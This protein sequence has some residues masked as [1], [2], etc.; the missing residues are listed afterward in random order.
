MDGR[1]GEGDHVQAAGSQFPFACP[2]A[3]ASILGSRRADRR[4]AREEPVPET[5][6]EILVGGGHEQ[7]RYRWVGLFLPWT[8]LDACFD[9]IQEPLHSRRLTGVPQQADIQPRLC[10]LVRSPA[11]SSSREKHPLPSCRSV[12]A[13]WAGSSSGFYLDLCHVCKAAH[14]GRHSS[15]G[16]GLH[17]PAGQSRGCHVCY[18]AGN[19]STTIAPLLVTRVPRAAP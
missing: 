16:S 6:G 15:R 3:S 5:V 17:Q 11:C 10:S 1:P 18:R 14:T 7:T 9:A 13:S 12:R 4:E 19:G 8:C 2:L